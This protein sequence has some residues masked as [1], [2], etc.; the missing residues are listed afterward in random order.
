MVETKRLFLALWPDA[1][2]RAGIAGLSRGLVMP[3]RKVPAENLHATLVFLGS[4]DDERARC[5]VSAC[6]AVKSAAFDL[7]LREIQF[8]RRSRMAWLTPSAEVPAMLELVEALLSAIRACGHVRERRP[9]RAHVT[10][11]RD[12]RNRPSAPVFEPIVWP[13]REF[14]LVQSTVGPAGSVYS[15]LCRWPLVSS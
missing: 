1:W 2:V 10:L 5:V 13:V 4:L 12:M 7:I 14:C 6:A 8:P 3:G 11:M 9:F 15:V